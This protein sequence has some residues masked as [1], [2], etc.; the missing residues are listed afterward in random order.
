LAGGIALGAV[1]LLAADQLL[2]ERRPPHRIEN[3]DRFP[4]VQPTPRH[5][6]LAERRLFWLLKLDFSLRDEGK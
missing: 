6:L 4:N 3:F 1:S 2:S 5:D